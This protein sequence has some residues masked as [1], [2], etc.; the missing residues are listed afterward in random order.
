MNKYIIIIQGDSY[1][2]EK[3]NK[4]GIFE[5]DIKKAQQFNSKEEAEKIAEKELKNCRC[6]WFIKTYEEA[7]KDFYN[8]HFIEIN[9]IEYKY[10][11][12]LD[13]K[14]ACKLMKQGK[15]ILYNND[16]ITEILNKNTETIPVNYVL[17]GTW[18]LIE[19]V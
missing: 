19:E 15:L 10:I 17:N 12:Y 13:V 3:Y 11:R 18:I 9:G 7:Y 14:E 2:N 4:T 1:Y 16:Y 5:I 6:F 8:K